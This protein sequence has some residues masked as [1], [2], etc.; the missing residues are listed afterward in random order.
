MNPIREAL[1][2]AREH[3]KEAERLSM[4]EYIKQQDDQI[5]RVLVGIAM[6][7]TALDEEPENTGDSVSKPNEWNDGELVCK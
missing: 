5:Q 7:L 1:K 3:M 4:E 6:A 2:Q